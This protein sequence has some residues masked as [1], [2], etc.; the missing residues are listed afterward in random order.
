MRWASVNVGVTGPTS[1]AVSPGP[2]QG[3]AGP[4]PGGR[5]AWSP[6]SSFPAPSSPCLVLLLGDDRGWPQQRVW[7]CVFFLSRRGD[8]GRDRDEWAHR[9]HQ[10]TVCGSGPAQRGAESH[11]DQPVHSAPLHYAGPGQP[12][13]G[14]PAAAHQLLPPRCAPGEG[15]P[16]SFPRQSDRAGR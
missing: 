9:G 8:E 16:M 1:I 12:P 14:L 6:A 15:P 10:A 7:L 4:P 3:G 13:L 5:G 2:A 11:P